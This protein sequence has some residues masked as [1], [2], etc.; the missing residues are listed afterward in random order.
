[1][2]MDQLSLFDMVQQELKPGDY[3]KTHGPPIPPEERP[4]YVGKLVVTDCS[5]E[6]FVWY[7]VARLEKY[8]PY[9]EALGIYQ[10]V[11]SHG[12]KHLG[13]ITHYPFKGPG[14]QIFELRPCDEKNEGYIERV[15]T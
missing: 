13:F 4:N 8:I 10:S 7:R 5:T 12:T 2:V 6:S 11:L 9:D 1:M 3:V 14:Y 15:K